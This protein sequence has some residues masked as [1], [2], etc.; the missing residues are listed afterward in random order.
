MMKPVLPLLALLTSAASPPADPVCVSAFR[1]RIQPIFNVN[2]V[3]CHQ[4]AAPAGG[5][6]L[7][8]TSAPASVLGVTSQEAAMLRVAPGKPQQSYLYRKLAG[9]HVEAGGSGERMP[10][11]GQ[12]TDADLHTV[13][14]WIAGCKAP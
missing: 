14:A 10:L 5:M 12:L 11:G 2:C 4:D 7:Q 13:E 3:A 6:S 8:R 1:E 9:T